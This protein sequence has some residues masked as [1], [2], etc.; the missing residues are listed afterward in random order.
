MPISPNN[1][2]LYIGPYALYIAFGQP[3]QQLTLGL[4][5][6]INLQV[7]YHQKVLK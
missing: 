6:T 2:H 5:E 3:S 1:L 7:Y 4:V